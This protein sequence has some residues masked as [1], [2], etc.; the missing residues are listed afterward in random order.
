MTEPLTQHP[1]AGFGPFVYRDE[2]LGAGGCGLIDTLHAWSWGGSV[3]E[4]GATLALGAGPKT[5]ARTIE[6]WVE[7]AAEAGTSTLSYDGGGITF[8]ASNGDYL[9]M[10]TE[11]KPTEST[12]HLGLVWWMKNSGTGG[13]GWN[14]RLFS[15][16]EGGESKFD[17]IVTYTSNAPSAV[18]FRC[19]GASS[20]TFTSGQVFDALFDGQLHQFGIEF[21]R[22][23][24]GYM[25][26]KFYLDGTLVSDRGLVSDSRGQ[27]TDTSSL[28]FRFGRGNGLNGSGMNGQLYRA[29]MQRPDVEG[30]RTMAETVALDRKLNLDRIAAAVA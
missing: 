18:E 28:K 17:A 22:N 27:W 16:Y 4:D 30:A 7:D 3:P 8:G 12:M 14:N 24:A 25:R 9:N 13:T 21:E 6:G 10:P 19:I 11:F 5:L 26:Q 20:W 29:M 2:A 1:V 23:G 15:M